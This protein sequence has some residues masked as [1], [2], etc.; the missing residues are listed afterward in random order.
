MAGDLVIKTA[1]KH[2]ATILPIDSEHNAIY[3]CLPAAIQADN[4]AIHHTSYGIKKTVAN[5]FWWQLFG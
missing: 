4:T 3:Q 2:G 1:K 5:S